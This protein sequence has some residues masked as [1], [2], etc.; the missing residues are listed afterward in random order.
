MSRK[1]PE[2]KRL[3]DG[4]PFHKQGAG[5]LAGRRP[6]GRAHRNDGQEGR[7]GNRSA[8]EWVIDQYRIKEDKPTGIRSGANDP[9]DPEHIVR[10]VGQVL[11]VSMETAKIVAALPQ[12]YAPAPEPPPSAP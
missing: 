6:G 11:R 1:N 7:L 2:P 10:L 3:R 12:H 5:S 8:I 9:D 4:K